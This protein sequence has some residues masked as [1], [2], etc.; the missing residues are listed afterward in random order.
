MERMFA[1]TTTWTRWL[2]LLV[3]AL[4]TGSA[5]ALRI[6]FH[7]A[8]S[9]GANATTIT[10]A[11]PANV[12]VGDVMLA[13]VTVRNTSA[14]NANVAWTALRNESPASNNMRQWLYYRV[15]TGTEPANYSW[16]IG[17]SAGR[18]LP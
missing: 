15:V 11:V 10:V 9:A 16:G 13:V 7:E 3:L 17:T 2:V 4:A 8:S 1:P 18:S 14:V 6:G 5:H 12:R